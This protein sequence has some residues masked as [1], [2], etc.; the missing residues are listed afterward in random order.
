MATISNSLNMLMKLTRFQASVTRK[1]EQL[2]VHGMGLNDLLIMHALHQAPLG[3]LR[4]V[5]LAEKIGVTASGITR[6]LI[7]MEKTGWVE[8]EAGE[9]DARVTYAVLTKEG[10]QLY[11]DAIKTANYIAADIIPPSK[12]DKHPLTQ[13]LQ[14]FDN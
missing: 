3:R 10:K 12:A 2:S 9:R 6:L 8:R 11:R 7:P 14:L 13:L 1:F 5:D 4:R